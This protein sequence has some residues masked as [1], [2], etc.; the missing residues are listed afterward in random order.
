MNILHIASISKEK[1]NGVN[2][3]VPKHVFY[4]NQFEKA[5]FVNINRCKIT[6]SK[7]QLTYLG[8]DKFPDYLQE[9]FNKPDL[10]I[11]H[12]VNYFEY[13]KIY[14]NLIKKNIPYIIIPHGE[15]STT[16]LHKKWIKKK[17][18]YILFFNNFIKNAKAIQFLSKNE[19]NNSKIK[20]QNSFISTNGIE[21]P[22][23]YKKFFNSDKTKLIYIGRLEVKIKGL[24][25]LIQAISKIKNFMINNNVT[26]EIYGPDFKGRY[27]QVNLLINKYNLANI[28][29]LNHAVYSDD[30]INKLLDSDLFIQTSRT[31]GMPLGIIEALSYG[32]PCIVT[33]GTSLMS[34]ITEN[35]CGYS[36]GNTL[37]DIADAII[38]AVEDKDNWKNKS[39]NAIKYS[40]ENFNW[41]NVSVA[42]IKNY[43]NLI[44]G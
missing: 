18:A 23:I 38:F 12:G 2:I 43:K 19:Q 44:K 4:Q 20:E 42:A 29:K 14:K 15:L 10:I 27:A 26:L 8:C 35:D 36:A 11:F 17:V 16:A 39:E 7:L 32:L 40:I 22:K 13:I 24:D 21:K 41:E 25:L 34:N 6:D 28:I 3:I 30:K 9:P 37:K 33:Q 5:A 31:E 1:H